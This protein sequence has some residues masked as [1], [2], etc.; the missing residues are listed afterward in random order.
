MA[1]AVYLH[2]CKNVSI[3]AYADLRA[4]YFLTKSGIEYN[5]KGNWVTHMF[6]IVIDPVW[7]VGMRVCVRVCP[8]GY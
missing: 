6:L 2:Y 1:Y 3:V 4:K 7:I 5:K 8:Q